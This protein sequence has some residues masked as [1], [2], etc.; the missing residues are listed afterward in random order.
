MTKIYG[1]VIEESSETW[2][3]KIIVLPLPLRAAATMTASR[4]LLSESLGDQTWM[5][6]FC[7]GTVH[8]SEFGGL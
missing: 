5:P 4:C 6:A 2:L 1:I 7:F 3:A 8:Q